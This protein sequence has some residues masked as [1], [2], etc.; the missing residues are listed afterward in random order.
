[1]AGGGVRTE[2]VERLH[3]GVREVREEKEP[4]LIHGMK[5]W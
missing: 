5:D 3:F 2:T 4:T 1:M